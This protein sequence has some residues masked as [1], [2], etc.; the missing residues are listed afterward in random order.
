M[1]GIVP[2]AVAE[3]EPTNE[4]DVQRRVVTT[5]DHKEFLVMGAEQA[6]SLIKQHLSAGVVDLTAE[7]LVGSAADRGGHALSVGSPDEAANFHSPTGQPREQIPDRR[8]ILEQSLVG[9]ATPI[10]EP[11]TVSRLQSRQLFMQ[12]GKVSRSMYQG[13]HE[14]AL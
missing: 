6:Y 14:V 11:H 5:A 1:A 13:P 12:P 2:T 3:V 9:V 7:E 10:G 8:T 4:R